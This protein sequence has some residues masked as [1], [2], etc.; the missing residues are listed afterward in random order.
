MPCSP[1]RIR[2]FPEAHPDVPTAIGGAIGG[3]AL[4]GWFKPGRCA[5]R[6]Q[7]RSCM[8]GLRRDGRVVSWRSALLRFTVSRSRAS[9]APA[10]RSAAFQLPAPVGRPVAGVSARTHRAA[11]I[12]RR[13]Q[14]APASIRERNEKLR[15][16]NVG[17]FFNIRCFLWMSADR[18]CHVARRP[19]VI[20]VFPDAACRR[21]RLSCGRAKEVSLKFSTQIAQRKNMMIDQE[22]FE[23]G[24]SG[25]PRFALRNK[26]ES[27]NFRATLNAA[28]SMLF[29]EPGRTT[30]TRDDD[31]TQLSGD[32]P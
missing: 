28:C 21:R 1:I 11:C 23:T 20:R 31:S 27:R 16:R 10:L 17:E 12:G 32:T 25:I 18:A 5:A 13:Q 8:R 2:S 9:G 26:K 7:W 4:R 14:R 29:H 24:R 3:F 22:Q 30:D 15:A 6:R 19:D